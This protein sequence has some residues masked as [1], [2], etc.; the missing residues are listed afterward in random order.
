MD[1]ET[2]RVGPS[3]DAV[4]LGDGRVAVGI[5][6]VC[7]S[8]SEADG[9]VRDFAGDDDSELLRVPSKEELTVDVAVCDGRVGLARR[10]VA[11]VKVGVRERVGEK[12]AVNVR[13]SFGVKEGEER[14]D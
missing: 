10:D 12:G 9:P 6:P 11:A 1:G 5:L 14:S 2:D 3:D 4:W 7:V 13:F 8:R